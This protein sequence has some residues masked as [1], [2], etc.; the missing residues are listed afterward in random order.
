MKLNNLINGKQENRRPVRFKRNKS[1]IIITLAT[2]IGLFLS[3]D[4]F[5]QEPELFSKV[6]DND[7]EALIAF[8]RAG[9]D[10]NQISD[11]IMEYTVLELAWDKLMMKV[12][13]NAGAHINLRNIRTG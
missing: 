1:R 4:L 11:D 5:S 13:I 7:I 12:L 9:A 8:I 3:A 6:R 10:V 2:G